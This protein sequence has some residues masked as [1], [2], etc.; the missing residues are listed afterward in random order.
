MRYRDKTLALCLAVVLLAGALLCVGLRQKTRD[1]QRQLEDTAAASAASEAA[2]NATNDAKVPLQEQAKALREQIREAQ[3]QKETSEA[4]AQ[5][6]SAQLEELAR[7]KT[8]TEAALAEARA[9][10]REAQT[11]ADALDAET[12]GLTAA[13]DA[14]RSALETGEPGPLREALET[15]R[16]LMP[17]VPNDK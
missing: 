10:Q 12:A 14:L 13:A 6:L 15:A 16:A 7:E 11:A 8:E 9:R 1:L 17:E 5:T 2:W 3:L 4:K